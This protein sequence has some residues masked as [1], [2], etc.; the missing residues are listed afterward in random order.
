MARNR[1]EVVCAESD[2][3]TIEPVGRSHPRL[4]ADG[5]VA[6]PPSLAPVASAPAPRTAV[7]GN[8]PWR[9]ADGPYARWGA[10]ALSLGLV[11]LV[12]PVALPL[13]VFGTALAMAANRSVR[14]PFLAQRRMGRGGRSFRMWKLRTMRPT[15]DVFGAWA[16]QDRRRTTSL[17]RLLRRTHLDEVP[18]LLNVLRGEMNLVGPRPELL[19][20]QAWAE[21]QVQGFERRLAVPPGLTGLAQLEVGYTGK[22][23]AAYAR[24]LEADL[25]YLTTRSLGGDL[26][27]MVRTPWVILRGLLAPRASQ[28]EVSPPSAEPCRR[29]AGSS[30]ASRG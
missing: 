19:P 7:T 26:L 16:D 29:G 5:G 24:K 20:I 8:R 18:Q 14:A 6:A 15:T 12:L 4:P 9:A 2:G 23:A 27:L 3:T 13:L 21:T 17:G 30:L 10:R 11:L 1:L 25:R 28:G 22:D